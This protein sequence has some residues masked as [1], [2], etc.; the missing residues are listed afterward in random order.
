MPVEV[1]GELTGLQDEVPPEKIEAIIAQIERDFDRPLTEVFKKFSPQPLGAASLAQA[2]L[3]QLPTGEEAVAKVLRPGIDI[4]VETD[5]KALA[6]AFQWLK[7]YKR[8]SRRVD[9]DWLAEEFTTV[10]RKELH[11]RLSE[12][13]DLYGGALYVKVIIPDDSG[14]S[15]N[16]A[17]SFTYNTL[18]QYDY[19]HQN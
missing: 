14:L 1:T 7:L 17:W 18:K 2:H 15:Y 6:L 16:E 9:L 5:L 3:V 13:K 8:V 10:T 11:E 19:Y 4:L 12:L